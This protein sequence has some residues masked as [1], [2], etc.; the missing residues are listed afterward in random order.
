ML[1]TMSEQCELPVNC[2]PVFHDLELELSTLA[3]LGFKQNEATSSWHLFGTRKSSETPTSERKVV[4]K[5]PLKE[6]PQE[7]ILSTCAQ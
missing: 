7:F 5:V 2:Q 4:E 6:E 1:N 3:S